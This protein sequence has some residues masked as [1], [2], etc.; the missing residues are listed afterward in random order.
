MANKREELLRVA[1][2]LAAADMPNLNSRVTDQEVARSMASLVVWAQ[3]LIGEVDEACAAERFSK[4]VREK[5]QAEQRVCDGSW[6]LGT[7]CGECK[8]CW[9]HGRFELGQDVRVK[10][11]GDRSFDGCTHAD[12]PSGD[13]MVYAII[14][15]APKKTY[16]VV[17]LD[18]TGERIPYA[19]DEIEPA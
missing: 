15:S 5:K 14:D 6:V 12:R 7:G 19:P 10:P 11:S 3:N 9:P 2:Q 17:W 8:R 4:R 1:T 16:L 18:N 13:G